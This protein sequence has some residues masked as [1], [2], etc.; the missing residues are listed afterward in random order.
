[1]TTDE[2][3]VATF[4]A[5]KQPEV[6]EGTRLYRR[7]NGQRTRKSIFPAPSPDVEHE[8]SIIGQ[9]GMIGVSQ[10]IQTVY[11]LLDR[12]I[13]SGYPSSILLTAHV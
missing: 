10:A 2:Q 6:A 5:G 11:G 4:M 13:A 8:R 12:I 9:Y 3:R 1:M 7:G